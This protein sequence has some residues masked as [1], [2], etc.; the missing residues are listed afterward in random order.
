M[1]NEKILVIND[2]AEI[3]SLTRLILEEQGYQ[4]F[5]APDGLKGVEHA[6]KTL[7]DLILLD[8][9]MP[10]MDGYETCKRLKSNSKTKN[11]PVIFLSSL[12]KPADKIKGLELG[13]VDFVNNVVDKGELLIRVKIQLELKSL[14]QAL[15][16]A[17]LQLTQKQEALDKDLKAAALIQRSFLPPA[18]MK[19]DQLNV[20]WS[21]TPSSRLGGDIFNVERHDTSK[22]VLYM[23]DVSGHDVPSALVTVSVSQFLHQKNTPAAPLLSPKEILAELDKEYPIERF[24]RFFTIAYLILDLTTGELSY[25]SAGHPPGVLLRPNQPPQLLN[26]GGPIIGLSG[27][28]SFDEESVKLTAGDKVILYTD[29]VTESESSNGQLF[30]AERLYALLDVIKKEPVERIVETVQ[31]TLTDFRQNK[32]SKDDISLLGFEFKGAELGAT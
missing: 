7:P 19:F 8:V 30:G 26:Q 23:L 25:S 2:E 18:K 14:T 5:D 11:T 22:I 27:N 15:R 32:H 29:G 4:V 9:M 13:A 6:L 17:N 3:R 28:F 10:E 31:Q 16:N 12:T 21:W 1:S 20:A 24:D